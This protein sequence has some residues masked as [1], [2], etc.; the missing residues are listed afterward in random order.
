MALRPLPT[1]EA[2]AARAKE[3]TTS[4]PARF[5]Q[6]VEDVVVHRERLA[7]PLIDEVVTLGECEPSLLVAIAGDD[8]VRS[9]VHV[10]YGSFTDL[11]ARDPRF[12]VDREL[13][14]TIRHEI[15][16][17]LEDRAGVRTLIDEDDL[18][19]ALHRFQAGLENPA[20]WWR[21]GT[22]LERGVW[23]VGDDLFVELR[24]RRPEFE[25]RRGTTVA[26]TVLGEAFE[27]E[28]PSDAEAGEVLTYEGEGLLAA[29]DDPG[30]RHV[31]RPDARRA[32]PSDEDDDSAAGDLHLVL[33]VGPAKGA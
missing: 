33:D 24:L 27:A 25:A 15:Q 31:S 14:E 5:L 3:I 10:Y 29:D 2:F 22:R 9:I 18:V 7:H 6:G 17:H 4:I 23:A 12:D 16:H 20:G 21:R 26:L 8:A 32:D 11:A 1:Y 28:I 13:E 19:D 30:H